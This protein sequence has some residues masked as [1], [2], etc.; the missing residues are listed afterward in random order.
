MTATTDLRIVDVLNHSRDIETAVEKRLRSEGHAL[1]AA[2][3]RIILLAHEYPG[4]QPTVIA[5]YLHQ[6]THSVSGL[7]NRAEDV[8]LLER[9]RGR[10]DR[11]N[12]FVHLTAAGE[13]LVPLL[14]GVMQAV[15]EE[16]GK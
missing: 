14:Q 10:E 2:Q 12:V 4:I 5:L 9:R 13:A 1:S 6:A 15:E 7:L 16:M 3:V 11:R 8:G